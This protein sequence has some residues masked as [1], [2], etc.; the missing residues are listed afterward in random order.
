V[1]PGQEIVKWLKPAGCALV[2][3]ITALVMILLFTSGKDPVR[4]YAA[5]RTSEYYAGHPEELRAEL[6]QNVF[7][8]LEGVESCE[9]TEEGKLRITL[10]GED[11]AVARSAILRYY[12]SIL[13][14]FVAPSG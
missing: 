5:P 4:G 12:D 1:N 10:V 3:L 9:V 11:Y 6:E 14:E 13:F 7:P 8:A 2:L